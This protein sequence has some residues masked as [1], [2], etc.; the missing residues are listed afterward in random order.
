[1]AEF[2]ASEVEEEDFGIVIAEGQ[3][4]VEV[5]VGRTWCEKT[6]AH[7]ERVAIGNLEF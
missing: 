1:M 3:D 4:W 7:V 5:R 2:E 6:E